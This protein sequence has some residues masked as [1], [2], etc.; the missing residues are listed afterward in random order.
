MAKI[1]QEKKAYRNQ[2]WLWFSLSIGFCL[3]FGLVSGYYAFSH[4]Y[5]IQDDARQHVVWLQKFIDPEL[6]P[7]DL[8]ANY[9]LSLAPIGYKLFYYLAAKI[10]F[11]PL[12]LAKILPLILGLIAT[13]YIFFLAI[14]LLPIPF[15]AFIISLF[16]N[17]LIWLEDDLISA[18]PRAFVYPLFAAFLYYLIKENLTLCLIVIFLQGLFYPQL[19]LVN[20][21]ILLVNLFE[22]NHNLKFKL[23]RNKNKYILFL[24]ATIILA[25]I[26][27]LLINKSPEFSTTINLEQMK[28]MPE[29]SLNGRHSFFGVNILDF[30][31]QGRSGLDLPVFPSVVFSSLFLPLLIQKKVG[32]LGTTKLKISF[33]LNILISS[34]ALF[35]LAYILLPKLYLPSRYTAYSLRFLM[36]IAT[37]IMIATMLDLIYAWWQKKVKIRRNFCIQEKLL[38]ALISIFFSIILIFPLFPHVFIVWFQNWRVGIE[39]PVYQFLAQQPKDIIV[40]SLSAEINNIPAFSQRS[41]FVAE[42]FAL[43]YHPDYHHQIKI[44]IVNLLQALYTQ[45]IRE[46]KQFINQNKINYFILD[47]QSFLPEYLEQKQWLIYSSWQE[48]VKQIIKQ[49]K[50]GQTPILKELIKPCQVISTKNLDLIDTSC[51]LNQ[52]EKF[53]PK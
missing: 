51:I 45:N 34:L 6:F 10:G 46:L 12:F 37:G 25:V 36:A 14:Q 5:I 33:L 32:I 7:N 42:E 20:N 52:N 38:L 30:W 8:I 21:T 22:F 28:N 11:E 48:V 19:L 17:Q 4:D 43:A 47:K 13:V 50:N 29:F 3:Y 31:H 49:L 44:R 26:V 35:I 41:V 27:F 2:F 16:F 18:T 9:Y 53:L 23:T 1:M 15:Y 24:S 40:A 39:T